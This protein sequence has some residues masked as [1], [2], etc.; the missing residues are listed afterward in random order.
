[1]IESAAIDTILAHAGCDPD[2]ATGAVIPPLHLATTFERDAD[3]E[4]SRGFI[5][6]RNE[7][8]TR[9][10]FEETLARLEGGASCLAFA[11]GMAAST[12]LLQT[13]RPGDHIILASDLYYGMRRLVQTLFADWGVEHDEVDFSD[14]ENL[15]AAARP[16]TR[17]VWVESPSNPL[18]NLIDLRAAAE[19]AHAVNAL[20]VVDNS[21][22]TPVLQRPLE[23][24]ADVVVHSVTKYLSGHSDVLG[25]AVVF[26]RESDL[27]ERVRHIQVAAGAV[28]DPFSAWLSLRG[29]R[30]LSARLR[31]QC[32]NARQIAAFLNNHLAVERTNFPGL[33]EHPGHAIAA[34]QMRDFGGMLS[35]EV[36]GGMD[37]AMRVAG[38]TRIFRRATS[39][40][41][42]ESLIEH[43]A[44][45]EGGSSAVPENLLRLS[46]GLEDPDDLVSDLSRALEA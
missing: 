39:L 1:M 19:A 2:P 33:P 4:Y 41:G 34:H 24:E 27:S 35:F 15:A 38:A 37:R 6:S 25:G 30:S 32:R 17:M 3:G 16:N 20:L 22:A 36:V 26:A 12:A 44:S 11:S 18:L 42:T 29:M 10:L 8:P 40:G 43:R 45:L 9:L 46:I 28:M 31:V 23:L 14:V 13:L 5:Y 21:W 7:N